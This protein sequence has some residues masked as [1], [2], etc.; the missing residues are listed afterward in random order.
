MSKPT[1][2]NFF[3]FSLIVVKSFNKVK[4]FIPTAR[5]R[6]ITLL[7]LHPGYKSIIIYLL[8]INKTKEFNLKCIFKKVNKFQTKFTPSM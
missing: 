7:R 8:E 2:I 4:F 1:T 6:T 3:N 5:S